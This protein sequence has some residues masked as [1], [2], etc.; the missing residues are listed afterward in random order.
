MWSCEAT[1]TAHA[2]RSYPTVA[3]LTSAEWRSALIHF[4]TEAS[5]GNNS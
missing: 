5:P 1:D 3:R 2:Q 4:S